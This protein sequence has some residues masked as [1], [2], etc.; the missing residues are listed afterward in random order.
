MCVCGGGGGWGGCILCRNQPSPISTS[1]KT[2][3]GELPLM[4]GL[5]V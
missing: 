3:I 4:E 1:L 2:N 5:V